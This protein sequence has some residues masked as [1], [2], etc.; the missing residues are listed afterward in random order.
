MTEKLTEVEVRV[1]GALIEKQ[2][3]TPEYYPLTLNSLVAACNQKNN[4]EPVVA[5]DE[6]I[7]TKALE[8]LREKNIVMFFTEAR[9]VC[10]NINI[11]CPMFWNSNRRKPLSCAF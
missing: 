7:V 1:V 4:R 6:E 9:A 3:T 8:N 5:F 11:S 10:R 2:L